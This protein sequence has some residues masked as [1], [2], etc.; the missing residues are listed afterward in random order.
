MAATDIEPESPIIS[1]TSEDWEIVQEES[2]NQPVIVKFWAP[3]C[4]SCMSDTKS[5]KKKSSPYLDKNVKF[6]E[7]NIGKD[8][9]LPR[10]YGMR[11][12]P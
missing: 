7:C 2:K 4:T 9:T 11:A 12:L 6:V 8:Y 5:F 10:K 1:I 3:W